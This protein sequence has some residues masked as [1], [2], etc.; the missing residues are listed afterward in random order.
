MGGFS[1]APR[2]ALSTGS[3]TQKDF[4]S[5]LRKD[6]IQNQ[7]IQ[8]IPPSTPSPHPRGDGWGVGGGVEVPC[9]G[10]VLS[11]FI[12]FFLSF[13]YLFLLFRFRGI[14]IYLFIYLIIK[15]K[16]KVDLINLR[17]KKEVELTFRGRDN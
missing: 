17:L 13:F 14:I 15:L 16:V 12:A 5:N 3:I 9:I 1:N 6:Y 7:H 11:F 8:I 4:Y 2:H 10:F